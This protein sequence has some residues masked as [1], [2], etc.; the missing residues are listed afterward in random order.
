MGAEFR[1]E[2]HRVQAQ[3]PGDV[4]GIADVYQ[5]FRAE[6]EGVPA[7]VLACALEN[8]VQ[9]SVALHCDIIGNLMEVI[10]DEFARAQ[11]SASSSTDAPDLER[12][13]DVSE[14]CIYEHVVESGVEG[15]RSVCTTSVNEE[16]TMIKGSVVVWHVQ[17]RKRHIWWEGVK[18]ACNIWNCGTPEM[19]S[20]G[21]TFYSPPP[22]FDDCPMCF[23]RIGIRTRRI[24]K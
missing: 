17:N 23:I 1:T 12:N 5:D 9:D 19:P 24:G 2:C 8:N 14:P 10:D 16:L 4:H 13:Q 18:S 21:A 11:A 3:F 22:T 15:A 20:R 7:D 6:C